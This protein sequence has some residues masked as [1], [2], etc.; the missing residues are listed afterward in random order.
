MS[1]VKIGTFNANSI[2]VRLNQI[3]AWLDDEQ[4]DILQ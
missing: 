2:R 4:I 3:L 1:Q